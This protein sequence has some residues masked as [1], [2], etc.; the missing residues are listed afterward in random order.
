MGREGEGRWGGGGGGG[1]G[2]KRKGRMSGGD[3]GS[4]RE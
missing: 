2:K 3:R 4:E 1:G